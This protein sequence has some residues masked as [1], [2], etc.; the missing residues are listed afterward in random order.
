MINLNWILKS[1]IMLRNQEKRVGGYLKDVI[2]Q[3]IE[4]D[5]LA[6]N[7]KV[8]NET[9]LSNKKQEYENKINIYRTEKLDS[10]KKNAKN[11]AE[12]AEAFILEIEKKH[13]TKV[14]AMSSAMEKKYKQ[15]EMDLIQKIFKKLFVLEG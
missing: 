9:V 12:D 10:A 13:D 7:N 14:Q 1:A 11:T 15:I 6:F 4:V 2:E 5:S 3:I 8:K